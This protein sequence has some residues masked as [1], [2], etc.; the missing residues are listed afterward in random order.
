MI[1]GPLHQCPIAQSLRQRQN[2]QSSQPES[3]RVRPLA[4]PEGP[5][6]IRTFASFPYCYMTPSANL[7]VKPNI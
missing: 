5:G 6:A 3:G 7:P 4:L 2:H 1:H